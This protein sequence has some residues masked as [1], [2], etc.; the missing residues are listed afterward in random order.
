MAFS[1]VI[2]DDW[3]WSNLL[4]YF[5]LRFHSVF[6]LSATLTNLNFVRHQLKYNC[7]TNCKA[8]SKNER[9]VLWNKLTIL[10]PAFRS[11]VQINF[12]LCF[13]LI[14]RSEIIWDKLDQIIAS[15]SQFIKRSLEVCL[16]IRNTSYYSKNGGLYTNIHLG[17]EITFY[18]FHVHWWN[19]KDFLQ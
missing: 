13:W 7:E 19:N 16:T 5:N 4:I 3:N 6:T 9:S 17:H 1:N 18:P 12:Q 14:W 10:D 2:F 15:G 8:K 11:Q